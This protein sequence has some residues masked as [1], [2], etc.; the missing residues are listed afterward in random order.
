MMPLVPY[1]SMPCFSPGGYFSFPREVDGGAQVYPWPTSWQCDSTVFPR[2]FK[3]EQFE[4]F[5]RGRKQRVQFERWVSAS[6]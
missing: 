5:W 1:D 2:M 6:G 4:I 3:I